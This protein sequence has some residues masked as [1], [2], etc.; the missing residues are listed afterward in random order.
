MGKFI[1][2]DKDIYWT[3]YNALSYNKMFNFIVSGTGIG[4]T[5]AMK[6]FC[7]GRF[8][9]YREQFMW[10][11]RY[12]EDNKDILTF[13]GQVDVLEQLG[14]TADDW[15]ID[16]KGKIWHLRSVD[17]N[18]NYIEYNGETEKYIEKCGKWEV[19]GFW[20]C[21][22]QLMKKGSEYP[23]VFWMVFEEFIPHNFYQRYL[24]DEFTMFLKAW[25]AVHR[26]I[27]E[28]KVF[29]LGNNESLYNPYMLA[30]GCTEKP[31][32]RFWTSDEND[33]TREC[34]VEFCDN[35]EIE[36]AHKQTRMGRMIACTKYGAHA[37]ENESLLL[38]NNFIG[39]KGGFSVPIFNI[40]IDNATYGVWADKKAQKFYVSENICAGLQTYALRNTD[41]TP[42]T[43]ALRIIKTSP[44]WRSILY[45]YDCSNMYFETQKAKAAMMT[46]IKDG[47]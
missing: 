16:N 7:L 9:K 42:D 44:M 2:Y 22:N 3:P 1:K 46:I 30:I 32:G 26:Y 8:K 6:K 38:N 11:R 27:R 41:H 10:L 29:F 21:L 31:P 28:V 5:F 34:L 12:D 37:L 39:K 33:L 45:A 14:D 43:M 13:F 18:G 35:K 4:K 19:A 15:K 24:P 20:K 25:D 23:C 36:E 17:E 40:I 47:M